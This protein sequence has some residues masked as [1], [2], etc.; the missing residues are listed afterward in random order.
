MAEWT[1]DEYRAARKRLRGMA[2]RCFPV[3]GVG[4]Y[5]NG[6]VFGFSGGMQTNGG[7]DCLKRESVELRRHVQRLSKIALRL[8]LRL[9]E[10]DDREGC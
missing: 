2:E 3:D 5:D 7:C 9:E 1:D 6:C 4:C 10:L 8:A